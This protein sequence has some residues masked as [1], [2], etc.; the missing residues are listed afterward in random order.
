M[1]LKNSFGRWSFRY[2]VP[3]NVVP[4]LGQKEITREFTETDEE[5]LRRLDVA[6]KIVADDLM[7]FI[8]THDNLPPDAI[9]RLYRRFREIIEVVEDWSK[10]VKEP[11]AYLSKLP[12][13]ATVKTCVDEKDLASPVV[14]SG[15]LK[16]TLWDLRKLA[17]TLNKAC[18]MTFANSATGPVSTTGSSDEEPAEELLMASDLVEGFLE[19]RKPLI[20]AKMLKKH[21]DI[22]KLFLRI[23]G[24]RPIKE[25]K[26]PDVRYF[27]TAMQRLPSNIHTRFPGMTIEEALSGKALPP[28]YKL[29]TVNS[30]LASVSA[31]FSWAEDNGYIETNPARRMGIRQKRRVDSVRDALSYADLKLIF[32]KS[33][34]FT[35]CLAT[36]NRRTPGTKIIKDENLWLPL[37]ALFTGMRLHEMVGLDAVDVR[38][39]DGVRCFDIHSTKTRSLKS[40]WAERKIPVHDE[41]IRI[42]FLEYVAERQDKG[43]VPL[44]PRV[45]KQTAQVFVNRFSRF[46]LGYRR[47]I[48]ID[49]PG[50][51]FHSFRHTFITELKRLEVNPHLI[52][53]VAGHSNKS[54]M[55][56]RYGKAFR[57]T[58]LV[59]PIG[60]LRFDLNLSHLYM[61]R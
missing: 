1:P 16:A 54:E 8:S 53:E 34:L 10:A 31:F 59:K 28:Y 26:R 44:W 43:P 20:T 39:C 19:E 32:E 25:F 13:E 61:E 46:W 47:S 27:K 12:P 57:P 4:L 11:P 36:N 58:E 52:T 22:L 42:G 41:L 33:P 18:E 60:R 50:K 51:P 2:R 15:D 49:G 45:E 24:D 14:T 56:W 21:S 6:F 3:R 30:Y 35:G 29:S 5:R 7:E 9:R 48:G 38:E 23:V 40:V 55:F 17:A 37:I